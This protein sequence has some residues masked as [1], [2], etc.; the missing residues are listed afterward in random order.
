MAK[1]DTGWSKWEPIALQNGIDYHTYYRRV[2]RSNWD[3]QLAATKPL[4]DWE[5]RQAVSLSVR[6]SNSK[7]KVKL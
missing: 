4:M 3:Q 5:E 1:R 2:I 7:K 6:R